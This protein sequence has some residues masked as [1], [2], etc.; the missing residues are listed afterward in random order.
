VDERAPPDG[1]IESAEDLYQN[2]PCGYVSTRA[3][4]LITRTNGTFEAWTGYRCADLIAQRRFSE[5]LAPGG[6]I[7]YETHLAPLLAM[8]G[9]AREIALEIVCANGGRLPVLINAAVARDEAGEARGIR[10]T[11]FDA[12]SR[13]RYEQELLR[14]RQRAER[15]D[16][17]KA[18]FIAMI[19]HEI[20]SP[21]NVITSVRHLL[22]KTRLDPEQ[23]RLVQM[24][25]SSSQSL[26]GIVNS[27][28]DFGKLEA[29]KETLLESAFDLRGLVEQTLAAAG[30][31]AEEKQLSLESAVS[32]LPSGRLVG[33][34]GKI[35]QVLTNLLSNA[36]KFTERGF[37]RLVVHGAEAIGDTVVI[38]FEVVDTGIGIAA[39]RLE[40]IF[41][42]YA[43][44]AAET[45]ARYGGTGLG[46][47]ICKELV[48]LLGGDL[49][50][51]S[52]PGRGSRFAFALPLRLENTQTTPT[53]SQPGSH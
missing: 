27:V 48:A 2:A 28:L 12:T 21:L 47:A 1:P 11:V 23:A 51:A 45:S 41:E 29:G 44:A 25:R 19:N 7:Y 34:A 16:R 42:P 35:G 22:E 9:H 13:R 24:L 14:E 37:V 31:A 39:D 52:E 4:G 3:D 43:Q 46:L 33:D 53:G 10:I 30:A 50:V 5:L 26:L 20:R 38:T 36:I 40:V 15:A 17:I 32:Q 8:Q 49:T 6:R 18:R